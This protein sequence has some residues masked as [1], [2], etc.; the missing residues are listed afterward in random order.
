MSSKVEEAVPHSPLED[1]QALVAGCLLV[2]L[3]V[4]LF[5]QAGLLTGGTVGLAF[6]IHYVS[7]WPYGWIFFAIN[8]PFYVFA[9]RA[10]GA[11]FTFKTF[12]AV[13]LLSALVELLPRL[14]HI[15]HLNPV[16]AAVMGG[17]LA[18]LGLL[19]LI[20]HRASLGG[21]GVMAI[22]LQNR[23]RWR[24]GVTQMVADFVILCGAFFVRAPS[25]VLLSVLGALTLNLVIAI[26]H[27]T[28][29]YIGF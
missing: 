23:R 7:G 26:N 4:V 9:W 25:E 5:R 17:Q 20:R 18:G 1:I 16:F 21:L 6:L 28:G 15:D 10:L 11:A 14:I 2:A 27:R 22:Y 19:V 12:A 3:S 29:R 8:L 13:A 24:A